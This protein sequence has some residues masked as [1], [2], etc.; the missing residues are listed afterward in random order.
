MSLAFHE[1]NESARITKENKTKV[2]AIQ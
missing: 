2:Y 1:N